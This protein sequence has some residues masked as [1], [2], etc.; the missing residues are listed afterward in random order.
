MLDSSPSDDRHELQR[1]AEHGDAD[2][3]YR[4]AILTFEE[5]PATAYE[6][7][8]RA[9]AFGNWRAAYDLGNRVRNSDPD[10]AK[11]WYRLAIDSGEVAVLSGDAEALMVIVKLLLPE[12]PERA[13]YWCR[14]GAESGVVAAMTTL[15]VIL[16]DTDLTKADE[17]EEKA[18]A[19]GDARAMHNRAARFPTGS[20]ECFEWLRRA[21]MGGNIT[22]MMNFGELAVERGEFDEGVRWLEKA[23]DLGRDDA[24]QRLGYLL[25]ERDTDRSRYWTAKAAEHGNVKAMLVVGRLATKSGNIDDGVRWFDKAAHLGDTN[26]MF[27]LG[28]LL[29]SRDRAKGVYWTERAAELGNTQAMLVSGQLAVE[30]GN[31]DAGLR[32][33]EKAAD[34]GDTNAMRSLGQLLRHRDHV[35]SLY[36]TEKAAELGNI[37]AMKYAAVLLQA[38]DWERAT[39]WVARAADQGD[40]EAA[41]MLRRRPRRAPRLRLKGLSMAARA[42]ERKVRQEQTGD[43]SDDRTLYTID[44][45]GE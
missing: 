30:S 9:A 43:Q 20:A 36:W 22:S 29:E 1:D 7:L 35:S 16:R 42:L 28:R 3:M 40:L 33:F 44:P 27:L 19:L 31:V 10:A 8:R 37:K 45:D 11:G 25:K 6:M 5:D 17:W 39:A 34:L 4:L 13:A 38:D 23:A 14:H 15:A 41:E 12:D 2:A 21:A 18:I 32:W 26:A 24:M